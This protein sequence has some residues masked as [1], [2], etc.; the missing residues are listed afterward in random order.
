MSGRRRNLVVVVGCG[1]LG[2]LLAGR[3]SLGGTEVVVID[4]DE[5]TFDALPPVFSGF[6]VPGDATELAVL[7]KARV[8]Q[9]RVVVA[10][11]RDDSANMMVAQVAKKVLGARMAVAR[12]FD[13]A[14]ESIY[15]GLDIET[16]CPTGLA[17]DAVVERL[18]A[19]LAAPPQE[20]P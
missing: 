5:K 16:V 2:A 14:R 8:G 19:A 17:A 7:R 11:T 1:R 4:L 10:A 9:A 13:P 12:V 18:T 20:A 6:R 15:H 3:L